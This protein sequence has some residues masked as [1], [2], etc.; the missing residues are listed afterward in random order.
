MYD[1]HIHSSWSDGVL[2]EEEILE[3]VKEKGIKY[4]SLTDHDNIEGS[5]RIHER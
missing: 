4:F 1:F 2:N 3:K 5:K